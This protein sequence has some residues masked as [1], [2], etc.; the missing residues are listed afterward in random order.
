MKA[1]EPHLDARATRRHAGARDQD[2]GNKGIKKL[3]DMGCISIE[4]V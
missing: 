2:D 1:M 3:P 4:E